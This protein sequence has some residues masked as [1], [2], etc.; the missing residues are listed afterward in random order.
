MDD[1][2]PSRVNLPGTRSSRR[3]V[4]AWALYDWANSAYST[5]QITVLASYLLKDILPDNRGV[6]AYG[7]GIGL[8]MLVTAVLSPILGAVADA[9]ASKR[10][11]LA[12]TSLTGAVASFLMYFTSPANPWW[13]VL[14]YLISNLGYELSQ[15]FYNGFLPEIASEE[16][17]D[18][19]SAW[20]YGLGY[21][22]GGIALLIVI[23]MFKFHPLAETPEGIV[24]IKRIGLGLMGL[25]WGLFTI[26][27]IMI[28]RDKNPPTHSSESI[29]TATRRAF[30]E[31]GSTIRNVR[32][33]KMLAL[34]LIAFLFYNDGVQTMISQAS[35]FAF[36]VLSMGDADLAL[37]ILMIQFVAL[38]GAIFIGYLANRIGQKPTLVVCLL[39]WIAQLVAAYFVTTNTQFW[40]LAA[41]AAVVLGGTQSV[42]RSIMAV[43]TPPN[44]TAEFFGFF[45]LSGKAISMLGPMLFT[46]ILA[47][48]RNAHLAI[49]SLLIFFVAGL[50]VLYRVNIAE[51]QKQARTAP[52]LPGT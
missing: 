25:W 24:E 34:F 51:G 46:G 30:R 7:W 1:A 23:A 12:W 16:D 3:E 42:S 11:W 19:V 5:L 26:P 50:A 20:G 17:M 32:S 29:P 9:H 33:Y 52:E 38:P 40:I 15:C 36:E 49:S 37:V 4:F 8:T 45:N 41:V 10:Q 27:S 31:V 18:R 21:L 47:A 44:R 6:I 22:G 14:L 43:M 48:T 28:L 39:V 13:F 2:Q 35:T